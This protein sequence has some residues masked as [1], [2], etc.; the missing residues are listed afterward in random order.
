MTRSVTVTHNFETGHRLPHLE[1][2]CQSLH[3]HSWW[4]E[5]TVQAP[6]DPGIVVEFGPFKKAIRS[7]ID[8]HLDHG[9]MLGLNDPLLK[10]LAAHGKVFAFSEHYGGWPTVENVAGLLA[11]ISQDALRTFTRAHD[12]RVERV[13]V[14]ETSVNAAE[15]IN[16]APKTWER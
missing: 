11:E 15:W 12:A 9:L 2:K 7:W 10:T 4:V 1:G 6:G 3:G 13:R 5:V 14:S 16:D 8:D